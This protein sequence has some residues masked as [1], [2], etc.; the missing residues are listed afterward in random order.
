MMDRAGGGAETFRQAPRPREKPGCLDPA[1]REHHEGPSAPQTWV[2][3]GS[4]REQ[5]VPGGKLPSQGT[6]V[7]MYLGG[8][9]YSFN[10]HP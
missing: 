5:K 8:N 1:R 9:I 7:A 4:L 3:R 10:R 6:A 2:P